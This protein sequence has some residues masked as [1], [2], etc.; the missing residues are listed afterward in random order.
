MIFRTCSGASRF[1]SGGRW[2]PQSVQWRAR[3]I[4]LPAEVALS[5]VVGVVAF[6]VASAV[7]VAARHGHVPD[8][9]LGL[10]LL[11]IVL[12]VAR[13]AGIL[14]ALP[15]GVVVTEAYDWYFLPPLR[16][17]DAATVSVLG[18]LIA[19]AVS[20]G[21]VS[22]TIARNVVES[23]RARGDLA[24]EQ[25]ALRRVAT[26]VAGGAAPAEVF[27]AVADEL[28]RLLGAQSSF[29]ARLDDQHWDGRADADPWV[30]I[31]GS[32]GRIIM[33]TPV[34]TRVSLIPGMMMRAA[35]DTGKTASL[36]GEGLNIGPFASFAVRLGLHIGI[37]TPIKVGSR[38]WGV[39]VV[40]TT[41]EF[42]PGVE[43]R[44]ADFFELAAIAIANTETEAQLR[45][46]ADMHASLR[47]LALLIA[48]GQPPGQVFAAVI[49]E[50][51][52]HFG[53]G[54]TAW[55]LR[56]ELDG[57]VTL[58]AG[59]GPGGPQA[60]I[61]GVWQSRPAEGVVEKVKGTG[62]PA[63]VDDYRDLPEGQVPSL[64]GL[65]SGVGMPIHVNGRLWGMIA[66][67]VRQGHLPPDIEIRMTE[68]TDLLATAV[69]DAES[70]AELTRSRARI[71]SA[72]DET[73]RRIERDLHDGVQQSLVALALRLRSA[74]MDA[75]GRDEAH[76]EVDEVATNL[77]TV[78]EELRELS[79]GIHPAV[80][81]D[82]GLRPALRA[83][84]R[85][86]H[87]P[88]TVDVRF[89]G[90]LPYP[91]EVGAYYVVSE[92]LNNAVKHAGASNVAVEAEVSEGS[93]R[94][95][96]HDDGVGGADPERGTGLLGLKDRIQA[97]G[98]T[99]DVH[100]PVSGGTTVTCVIPVDQA[101]RR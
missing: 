19:M 37:A 41:G 91:V 77:M 21:V 31:V 27:A 32:Y 22:T 30:T 61:G 67:G 28:A 20:V 48:Q 25:E 12:A 36:T 35:V 45:R 100:S 71:V 86:S 56:F 14:Y 85:R 43:S 2:Q 96:V 23:E 54:G 63:R 97:L 57:T 26:L 99:F 70:R 1:V 9:V 55:L 78:I 34:G 87:V 3:R 73:R 66:I 60:E 6:V 46:L 8:L 42:Q 53:Q 90:R 94:L 80:L 58:L 17:I 88:V 92:M 15:V 95:R 79:R 33:S 10:A 72:S 52:R 11:A 62:R 93:L 83:L 74:A 65:T 47:R 50:V 13:T 49:K 16:H 44:I 59:E 40:A 89:D 69:A 76:E 39:S 98:G 64:G 101:T 51:L 4:P 82:S 84:A 75:A 81:S 7:C 18:L 29:V 68:F 38:V 5:V 24:D